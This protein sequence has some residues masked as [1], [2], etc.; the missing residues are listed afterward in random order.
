MCEGV[1]RQKC[2]R[3]VAVIPCE[4][5]EGGQRWTDG[6]IHYFDDGTVT[7]A[8]GGSVVDLVEY[9]GPFPVPDQSAETQSTTAVAGG[10]SEDPGRI[11]FD[12]E[13]RLKTANAEISYQ[14]AESER[15]LADWLSQSTTA[16]QL[17]SEGDRLRA[18]NE[19]LQAEWQ[20]EF[21]AAQQLRSEG[22]Q[23]ERLLD[24][25][26]DNLRVLEADGTAMD[27]RA[28]G[29]RSAYLAVIKTLWEMRR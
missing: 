16:Q 19:R 23:L 11:I 25:A 2:G 15:L 8:E 14:A 7:F 20:A 12:L 1:W 17:R 18:E 9:V 5:R 4:R 27:N 3:Y 22:E 26:R 13:E 24:D 29:A 28:E 21:T 10:V 6:I